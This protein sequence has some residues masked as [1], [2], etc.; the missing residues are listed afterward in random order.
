MTTL[1]HHN[2]E[3]KCWDV[4]IRYC[5][6]QVVNSSIKKYFTDTFDL[7]LCTSSIL[8]VCNKVVYFTVR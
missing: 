1:R 4:F 6:T 5:S 8:L 3:L 7:L 2:T